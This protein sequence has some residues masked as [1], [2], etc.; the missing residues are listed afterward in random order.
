MKKHAS[1]RR[2]LFVLLHAV[3][4]IVALQ[5]SAAVG[6]E[7]FPIRPHAETQDL[8]LKLM[9]P[10][11]DGDPTTRWL[12]IERLQLLAADDNQKFVEQV[13]F[14]VA[15][16]KEK[17]LGSVVYRIFGYCLISNDTWFQVMSRYAYCENEQLRKDARRTLRGMPSGN[18]QNYQD[19]GYL[20]P[21]VR[22]EQV[23]DDVA[24]SA[25]RWIFETAPN[26]A[27]LLFISEAKGQE[28]SRMRRL[29]RVI[30][31]AQF[32][33]MYMGGIEGN[34]G[35]ITKETQDAVRELAKSPHWWAR[36][37][38]AETMVQNYEFRLD[39]V[40]ATLAEDPDP[41]VKQSIGSLKKPDPLRASRVDDGRQLG[42]HL[43]PKPSK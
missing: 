13:A 23:G 2:S 41:L 4:L 31:N 33:K 43:R 10:A 6:E 17:V 30:S 39:D 32:D 16:M 27:F 40:I 11:D 3:V 15:H 22:N 21:V 38:V 9:S 37:F 12:A 25:K 24:G 1:H 7:A 14:Y 19:L 8:I 20:A 35:L 26:S 42:E 36:F 5:T 34:G 28:N 29:E 18:Y